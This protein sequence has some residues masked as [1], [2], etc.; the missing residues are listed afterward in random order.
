M[1]K[2]YTRLSLAAPA[3]VLVMGLG[4]TTA[5]AATA[6]TVQPGGTVTFNVSPPQSI[7]SP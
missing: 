1:S 3:A 2:R 4:V 7:T 6:W 5:L